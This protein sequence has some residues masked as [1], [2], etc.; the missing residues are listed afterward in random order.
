[1]Y[2]FFWPWGDFSGPPST[3]PWQQTG[4]PNPAVGIPISVYLCPADSRNLK[5]EDEDW[6]GSGKYFTPTCFTEYLGVA[7]FRTAAWTYVGSSATPPEKA[8]GVL[9]YRSKVRITDMTD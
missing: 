8:D 4:T 6:F 1:M 5:V 9:Y 2:R 7:G 3:P